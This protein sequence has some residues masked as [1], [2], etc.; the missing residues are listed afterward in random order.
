MRRAL[1]AVGLV[2][3]LGQVVLL[4]EGLVAAYG[5][6]L[7]ALSGLGLWL[8][9]TALGA[10]AGRAL[11]PPTARGA[12]GLRRNELFKQLLQ[13]LIELSAAMSEERSILESL[14]N[15]IQVRGR[16]VEKGDLPYTVAE[17]YGQQEGDE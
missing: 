9:G 6:E 7:A 15:P 3:L 1:F 16:K 5:V 4:R 8:A 11:G 17:S 2:S 12:R 10:A 13:A 14:S